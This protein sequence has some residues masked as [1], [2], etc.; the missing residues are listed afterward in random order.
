M[1][2]WVRPIGEVT[3][4]CPPTS[5]GNQCKRP[6]D[7]HP[8]DQ[9]HPGGRAVLQLRPLLHGDGGTSLRLGSHQ[10]HDEQH[11]ERQAAGKPGK[12][13]DVPRSYFFERLAAIPMT[14]PPTKV[15]GML[16]KAPMAAAPKACTT[17]NVRRDGVQADEGQHEHAGERRE[18]GSR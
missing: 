10:Q 13:A 1:I 8:G 7:D 12:P 6:E 2:I 16:E 18:G 14:R 5:C 3:R 11:D 15:S 17:R 9:P 4:G